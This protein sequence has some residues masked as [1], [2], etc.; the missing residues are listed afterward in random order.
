MSFK[1]L[2]SVTRTATAKSI[3][4]S[5]LESSRSCTHTA[6]AGQMVEL[7][8]LYCRPLSCRLLSMAL[9]EMR[10]TR[11]RCGKGGRS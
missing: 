10:E 3:E 5:A 1:L 6:I 4:P 9:K 7:I 11:A 8:E 2:E